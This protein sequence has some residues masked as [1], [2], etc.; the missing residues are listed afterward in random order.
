MI[1]QKQMRSPLQT[2]PELQDIEGKNVG[3][4]P[5]LILL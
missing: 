3:H 1:D 5:A 2:L 4:V